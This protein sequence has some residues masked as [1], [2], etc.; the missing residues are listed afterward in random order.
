VTSAPGMIGRIIAGKYRV[1]ELLGEGSMGAVYGANQL[2]LGKSV[3]LKV[4]R[5]ELAQ[6]AEFAE[7]F[8][9]EAQA[10]SRLSHPN[11][12]QVTDFGAEPDGLLYLVMERAQ[13]VTL[14]ALLS[15]TGALP[16]SRIAAIMS[17]ILS[18][19]AVAHDAGI[20]HRDLKPENVLI[21]EGVDD[22]G[23]PTDVVKV[24]DFGIASIR[25]AEAIVGTETTDSPMSARL[26]AVGAIVGTPA[27]MAPEQAQGGN[28]DAR[29]DVYSAGIVLYE[30]LTGRIPFDGNSLLDLIAKHIHEVPKSPRIYNAMV[31]EHMANI[32]LRAI[33]KAPS[34]RFPNARAMKAEFKHLLANPFGALSGTMPLAAGSQPSF[35]VRSTP[36][37]MSGT[38]TETIST[39]TPRKPKRAYAP[40]AIATA[41]LLAIGGGL[42]YTQRHNREHH[43][44]VTQVPPATTATQVA[45]VVQPPLD[46]TPALVT[47]A[48]V[49]VAPSTSGRAFGSP[50]RMIAKGAIA[51]G[52][53]PS[54]LVASAQTASPVPEPPVAA[55]VEPP[56]VR[57][58]TVA[59]APATAVAAPE[60]AKPFTPDR[61]RVRAA[62]GAASRINRP[63]VQLIV[64]RINFDSCYQS[65]IRTLGHN[66][67]GV[68]AA[69]V[70]I[71]EDGVFRVA[72]LTVP[73]ALSGAK[74]CIAAKL[75]GQRVPSPPDTGN[76][77]ADISLTFDVP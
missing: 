38:M 7:R 55:I 47:A 44:T 35:G 14:D 4:M 11:S 67:A 40:L 39:L 54:A 61:A 63:A 41:L 65:A 48:F 9:R 33:A 42:L 75:Q 15:S 23:N 24:C 76:A 13:G 22:D 45:L 46:P 62:V 20:V 3:A 2:A 51:D 19:L 26:T 72:S 6:S 73:S 37:E 31:S 59:P 53:L 74:S 17:Q 58:A 28:F 49:P 77:S 10:A 29:S 60:P 71:D 70:E 66:E 21:V 56:P 34:D 43:P 25:G 50:A 64:G 8:Q 32:C 36:L 69:H 27:Y 30:L 18:A 57:S 52:P 16:E 12:I 68:G 5:T 1:D